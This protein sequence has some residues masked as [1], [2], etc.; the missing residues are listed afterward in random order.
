M[1]FTPKSEEEIQSANLLQPGI[2]N[3]LVSKAEDTTS[4]SGN[5]MIKLTLTVWDNNGHEHIVFDYLLEAIAYKVRHFSD[6]TSLLDKYL[7]GCLNAEDCLG[8][9]GH[10]SIIIQDG[11]AKGDGTNYPNRNAVKDYIKKENSPVVSN[12]EEFKDDEIPF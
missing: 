8:K 3:F 7:S 5:E 10:V 11:A 12:S 4:K 9:S 2:Y 6:A 1:N